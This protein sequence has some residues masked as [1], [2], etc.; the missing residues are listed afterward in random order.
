MIHLPLSPQVLH[1]MLVP[2]HITL[3]R[4]LYKNDDAV[5][6]YVRDLRELK[7]QE[8]QQREAEERMPLMLNTAPLCCN[9]LDRNF[10]NI[11]CNDEAVRLFELR[12]QQNYSIIAGKLD[13][14]QAA[15]DLPKMLEEAIQPLIPHITDKGLEI[16]FDFSGDIPTQPKNMAKSFKE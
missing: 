11:A 3:V 5:A 4:I 14:E 8:A 6:A 2:A 1:G 10:N 13:L 9:F 12:N 7:I 16:I 15:F